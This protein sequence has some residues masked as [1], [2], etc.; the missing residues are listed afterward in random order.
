MSFPIR[1]TWM[2]NSTTTTTTTNMKVENK[3]KDVYTVVDFPKE[4]E[5][6]GRFTGSSPKRAANKAFTRLAKISKLNNTNRQFIVFTIL[7]LTNDKEYKY[8]G[9]RVKLVKPRTVNRGG[10]KIVYKY[11]NTVG[12]YK[13]VLNNIK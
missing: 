13:E 6:F 7:N 5:T 4:N 10:K 2:K 1:N 3:K 12:K 11:I 9:T 8:I